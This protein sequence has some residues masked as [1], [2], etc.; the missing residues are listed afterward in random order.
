M[1]TA[2]IDC[3][4]LGHNLSRVR[5]HLTPPCDILAVIKADAYGHGA[6]P[7]AKYLVTQGVSHFAVAT[8]SEGLTLRQYGIT[9]SIVIMGAL[10]LEEFR[11][12]IAHQLTPIVY[13]LDHAS[14]LRTLARAQAAPLPVHLKVDTGM[15]R[16]GLSV[17]DTFTLLQN[18]DLLQ[19]L[20]IE[21]IMSHLSDSDNTDHTFTH[22]QI[23]TFETILKA[24]HAH[25]LKVPFQHIANSSGILI[26]PS[27]HFT[28]VRPG[29]MLYGYHTLPPTHPPLDLKPV[30][31]LTSH[32][33]QVRS[34]PTGQSV[35]YN[36]T[37][38]TAR[39]SR[40]AVLPIGYADGLNRLLS[41]KGTVLIQ[42]HYAPIVGRV[43]MDMTMVDITDC[44]NVVVGE[45]AVLMGRQGQ[46]TI[47]AADL[48]RSLDT[49]PY[50]IL[51]SIGP[52]VQRTYL[53]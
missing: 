42:G 35:S 9:E 4:A 43:C 45:E 3:T 22:E 10:L 17:E 33:V 21:G 44:G 30:L 51:C 46:A 32:I 47:T 6:I 12:A 2:T 39:P 53:T 36:R 14:Q 20:K 11:E 34:L 37:F 40:I 5:H 23:H 27:S 26:H 41:N 8:L 38:T 16:L 52:R 15:G 48:A 29:I 50:E 31:S 7:V 19:C 13:S 1:T 25:H 24:F 28:M 18:H 49:I